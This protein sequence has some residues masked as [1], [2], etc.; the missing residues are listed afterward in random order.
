MDIILNFFKIEI[1]PTSR[2]DTPS[3]LFSTY[4]KSGFL[5]DVVAVI[6][7]SFIGMSRYISLRFLKLF[8]FSKYLSYFTEFVLV[9]T[10]SFINT[11]QSKIFKSLFKLCF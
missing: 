4:I 7:Y 1:T 9:F 6:P 5:I 8:E 10:S 2:I 3:E 11:K